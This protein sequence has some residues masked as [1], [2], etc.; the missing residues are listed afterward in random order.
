MKRRDLWV[1]YDSGVPPM[2]KQRFGSSGFSCAFGE[3]PK[4]KQRVD[5]RI[6]KTTEMDCVRQRSK[7]KL[8]NYHSAL[9]VGSTDQKK[10]SLARRERISKY[11]FFLF[12]II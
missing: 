10:F 5:L 1:P 9:P 8:E 12:L 2:K 7:C 6:V 4:K 11:L 3:P